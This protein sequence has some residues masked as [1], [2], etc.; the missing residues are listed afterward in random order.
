VLGLTIERAVGGDR[1]RLVDV[2]GGGAVLAA[3]DLEACEARLV[4]VLRERFGRG[5]PNLE[6]PTLG[7][8]Q[9]WGDVFWYAG[10]RIQENVYTGHCRLLSPDDERH[11]W[12]PFEACRAAFEEVRVKRGLTLEGKH[13]VVLL[14]GLGRTRQT[15]APLREELRGAG[16]SV[17]AV[18]YPSTRR[19]LAEHADGLNALLS[20]IDDVQRISFVT[21]S[22]GGMVVRAALAAE[23]PWRERLELDS[24]VMLAPPSKGS[25]IARALVDFVPF[26]KLAGP[27]GVEVGGELGELPPPPPC[28]F[29]IVAGARRGDRGWNPLLE[30]A[31]DGVLAVEETELEGASDFLVVPGAH[32]FLMKDP[33]AIEAV[34]AFLRHGRFEAEPATEAGEPE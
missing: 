18:E 9:L 21:H 14:H 30:G 17:A 23:A 13:L 11:A 32:T 2:D 25:Q 1:H 7:G 22:L 34:L 5:Y 12:G 4:E 10:W 8:M 15:F 19:S 27:S 28:P 6:M 29:G 24:V 20:R 16:Y 31:D 33:K 26:R 3:G